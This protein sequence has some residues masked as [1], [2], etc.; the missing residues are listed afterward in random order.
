MQKCAFTFYN[1]QGRLDPSTKFL[2]S[3]N[4]TEYTLSKTVQYAEH[5]IPGLD[6]PILQFVRGQAETTSL[7]LFFDSSDLG[8][9]RTSTAVTETTDKFYRLARISGRLHAPPICLFSWGETGFAGSSLAG[10]WASQARR[11]GMNCV[12]ESLRQRFTLFSSEGV[13]LRATLTV[14]LKEYKSVQRQLDELNPQSADQT[15]AY[16]LRQGETLSDVANTVYGDPNAWRPIAE[17]NGVTDPLAVAAG[18]IL[19]IPP[20]A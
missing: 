16:T 10:D 20:L 6:S 11:H 3:Y 14:G 4:P 15:H 18:S 8:M 19:T 17:H 13:P 12:I 7:D 9:G 5:P 1:E 2:A